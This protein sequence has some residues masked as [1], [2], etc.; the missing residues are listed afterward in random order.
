MRSS[1]SCA[2]VAHPVTHENCIGLF[3]R[4]GAENA[5]SAE[6][7]F[8]LRPLRSQ[9]LCG[10]FLSICEAGLWLCNAQSFEGQ[11]FGSG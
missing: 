2:L 5:E 4:R 8:S 3:H 9:R 7:Y 10:K 11:Q 6:H 1:P